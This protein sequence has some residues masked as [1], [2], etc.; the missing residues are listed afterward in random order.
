MSG[1]QS[2]TDEIV[3]GFE[4]ND[5]SLKTMVEHFIWA[6]EHGLRHHTDLG[7]PMIPTFVTSV[8]TGREQ[9]T[10]LAIDL[11]GT[12][13][14][15]CSVKLNG[16]STYDIQQ[17]KAAV[18]HE[19][20]VGHSI[21]FFDYMAAQLEAFLKKHHGEHLAREGEERFKM[22]FT[23]SFPVDQTSLNRGTLIRWTKGFDIKDAVGQDV[24]LLLQNAIDRR[25]L[26]V[27][28]AA[29]VNDTVG[30]LMSRSYTKAR[31]GHTLVG[32]I[33]GTGTNGAY[34]ERIKAI[35]KFDRAAHPEVTQKIMVINT[36]WGSFDNRLLKIP[37]TRFDVALNE[38]TPNRGYHMFEKRISGMFLGELLRLVLAELRDSGLLFSDQGNGNGKLDTPWS[39][40]TSVPSLIDGDVSSGLVETERI[41][42]TYLGFTTSADERAQIQRLAKAIGR[43]SARLS[44]IPLAGLILH[45]KAMEKFEG[46]V[47]IGA[48]GSVV[49]FYPN[50]EKMVREALVATLG[51]DAAS[52]V[53]LGIAKDGSGVGAALCALVA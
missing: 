42:Q 30:T 21:E 27:H 5:E 23:F 16:D 47:D 8:P 51:P 52:R 11:G 24:C 33:F 50:F 1:L 40:D 49:Q 3:A 9:G 6:T 39:L 25:K 44:S 14:R 35:P 46:D 12:N 36:E 32:C 2:A 53:C 41:V 19:L 15:V 4:V 38:L 37:S 29:L 13:V 22:G 20:M 28:V 45:T 26:P 31:E 17:E 18:P 43:R 48:D 7:M 34:S 10:F